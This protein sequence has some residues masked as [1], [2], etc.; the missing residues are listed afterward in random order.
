MPSASNRLPF[1]KPL[2]ESTLE[3]MRTQE[4]IKFVVFQQNPLQ[5]IGRI[6]PLMGIHFPVFRFPD[7]MR[8][9]INGK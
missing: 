9:Q 6:V 5:E 4:A 1:G 3:A 2:A 7:R 8:A